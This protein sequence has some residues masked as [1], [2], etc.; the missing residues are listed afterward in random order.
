M[1][2]YALDV[3]PRERKI[4]IETF[5]LSTIRM[6]RVLKNSNTRIFDEKLECRADLHQVIFLGAV[7][8]IQRKSVSLKPTHMQN[9]FEATTGLRQ[10]VYL[11]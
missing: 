7:K 2:T 11:G 9:L 8:W 4:F 5:E 3:F 1:D 10:K 6:F